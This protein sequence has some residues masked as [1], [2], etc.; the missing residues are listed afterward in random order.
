VDVGAV[1]IGL[2]DFDD[3]IPYRIAG[4]VEDAPAEPGDGTRGGCDGVVDDKQ[5]V[6]AIERKSIGIVRPFS[7]RRREAECL[8]K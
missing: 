3:G 4:A 7:G 5:I 1:V 6:I 8:R 2:P